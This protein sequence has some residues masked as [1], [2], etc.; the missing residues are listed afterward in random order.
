MRGAI[1]LGVR[2]RFHIGGEAL[3][4]I[5]EHPPGRANEAPHPP[6]AVRDHLYQSPCLSPK[7]CSRDAIKR[8]RA[9]SLFSL[10]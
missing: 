1:C 9:A 8:A 2:G 3:Q 5:G 4:R 6:I 7:P 10:K